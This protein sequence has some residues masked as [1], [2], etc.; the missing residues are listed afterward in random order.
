[1]NNPIWG[2]KLQSFSQPAKFFWKKV[3]RGKEYD[4]QSFL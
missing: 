3:V 2:A 4:L 1:M